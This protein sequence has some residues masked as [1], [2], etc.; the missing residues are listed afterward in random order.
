MSE[1]S[2]ILTDSGTP[3]L[4]RLLIGISIASFFSVVAVSVA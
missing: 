3:Q 4:W 2:E 1:R